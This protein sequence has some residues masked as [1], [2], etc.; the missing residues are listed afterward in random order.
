MITLLLLV[1][2]FAPEHN[3]H[4]EARRRHLKSKKGSGSK[5]GG[6][7]GDGDRNGDLKEPTECMPFDHP[8]IADPLTRTQDE[9]ATNS[10]GGGCCR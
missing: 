2:V 8:L 6:G 3:R 7:S 1:L 5:D 4:A 9:C 10:C